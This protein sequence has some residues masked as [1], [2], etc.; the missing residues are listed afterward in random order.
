MTGASLRP[1]AAGAA[2]FG[3]VAESVEFADIHQN[4]PMSNPMGEDFNYAEEFK[5]LD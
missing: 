2:R 3:L 1:T 5:K 4:S